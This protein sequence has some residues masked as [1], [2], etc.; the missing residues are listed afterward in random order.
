MLFE[1]CLLSWT[2]TKGGA[3]AGP[4]RY[5]AV[6]LDLHPDIRFFPAIPEIRSSTAET[7]VLLPEQVPHTDARFNLSRAAMLVVALTKRPDLLVEATLVVPLDPAFEHGVIVL[8]GSLTID[9]ITIR[10]GSVA[11]LGVGRD[12]LFAHTDEHTRAMLIGGPPLESDLVMGWNF[13]GRNRDEIR[14]AGIDWNAGHERFGTVASPLA[15]IP[16]PEP[17]F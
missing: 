13:V 15:R 16:A 10:P 6:Q 17:G 7:R 12:E 5:G 3:D 14:Q 11:Y 9:G 4:T 2:V 8:E 1:A